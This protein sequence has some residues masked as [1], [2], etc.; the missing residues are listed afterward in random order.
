MVEGQNATFSDIDGKFTLPVSG[1]EV[2][3]VFSFIGY[4]SKEVWYAANPLVQWIGHRWIGRGHR[5]RCSRAR[6]PGGRYHRHRSHVFARARTEQALQGPAGVQVTQNSGQPGSTQS[7][8]IRGTGSWQTLHR[9][10][11]QWWHRLFESCGHRVHLHPRGCGFCGLWVPVET[12][13]LITADRQQRAEAS[14]YLRAITHPG[15]MEVH[16][17]SECRGVCDSHERKPFRS[18]TC[19]A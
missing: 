12:V 5:R 1:D 18:R 11:P 4:G 7:I 19:A 6:F 10:N 13:V 3:L 8:R 17:P 9:R 16:G 2:T 14:D 15:T